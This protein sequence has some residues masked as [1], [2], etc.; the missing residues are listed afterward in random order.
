MKLSSFLKLVEIQTKVASIIPFLFGSLYVYYR[1]HVF[2]VKNA[3]IMFA[4][5]IIFDMTTTMINNYMDYKRAIKKE[6]YGYE[7]HNAIVRDDL[8][9]NHVRILI[10]LMLG[11]SA[12]LGLLLVSETSN[13][14]LVL[15]VICFIIGIS[16]SYGPLPISRTPFGEI[17][18]GITMGLILTFIS[19]YIHIY[20]QKFIALQLESAHVELFMNVSQLLV[21]LIVCIPLTTGIANIMLANNICD[22]EDD[23][24]NH[25]YTLPICMGKERSLLLFFALYIFGYFSIIFGVMIGVLPFISLVTLITL[26]PVLDHIKQFIAAPSKQHTFI[27]SVK[28]FILI[29]V[30]YLLTILIAILF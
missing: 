2:S 15:G 17:F 13:L 20:D 18:S 9:P 26:K 25:R 21:L 16:Y 7:I 27:L 1:Y 4:S 5:M 29:N 28:N 24:V 30:V 8:S 19:M 3:I 12:S 10:V 14:V 23:L 11:L 22:M 6:G